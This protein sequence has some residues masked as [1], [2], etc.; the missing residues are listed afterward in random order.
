MGEALPGSRRGYLEGGENIRHGNFRMAG[1][2]VSRFAGAYRTGRHSS[3]A[4]LEYSLTVAKGKREDHQSSK[5]ISVSLFWFLDTSI[6]RLDNA[7]KPLI[8]SSN[9]SS[10]FT[11]N[12]SCSPAFSGDGLG[13]RGAGVL[14]RAC[15]GAIFLSTE[16][17]VLV[18]DA[19]DLVL[20][21]TL[22]I[23]AV[24]ADIYSFA[25]ERPYLIREEEDAELVAAVFLET[26]DWE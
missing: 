21:S 7:T 3:I 16:C 15:N 12:S 13:G 25:G 5:P 17:E 14:L 19:S 8:A 4:N 10:H 2:E 11:S 1:S 9:S 23:S 20:D 6:S 22:M 24:D 26:G 18:S